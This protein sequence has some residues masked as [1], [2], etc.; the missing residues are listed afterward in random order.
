MN[1]NPNGDD[2]EVLM[3]LV[4]VV[5]LV[6]SPATLLIPGV[7]EVVEKYRLPF[8]NVIFWLSVEV[9]EIKVEEVAPKLEVRI[10]SLLP[11]AKTLYLWFVPS[12]TGVSDHTMD[13]VDPLEK[14][15]LCRV[16]KL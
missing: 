2:P 10:P 8:T 7:P 1:T 6:G 5:E 4:A 16:V 14:L 12:E 13:L 15:L 9:L 11:D 3:R